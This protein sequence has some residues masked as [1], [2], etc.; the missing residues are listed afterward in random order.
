MV[1]ATIDIIGDPY[2]LD[3]TPAKSNFNDLKVA[4]YRTEKVILF[5]SLGPGEV[6]PDTGFVPEG[7]ARA[8]EFLT[9][10]YRVWKV[11][12]VF[13]NGQ[14]TQKLHVIRDTIT[15]LS[16]LTD[17]VTDKNADN[18]TNVEKPVARP[19]KEKDT[20]Q[21]EAKEET[22]VSKEDVVG[23]KKE[24]GAVNN[25][26]NDKTKEALKKNPNKGKLMIDGKEVSKE[27]YNAHYTQ[28][29]SGQKF[30]GYGSRYSEDKT[31][32]VGGF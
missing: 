20:V 13:D 11:D 21:N 6:D 22:N 5:S 25:Y 1:N 2:W 23:E 10:L 31:R 24:S 14:F 4:N 26:A 18:V 19:V 15:D 9:A 12:H 28:E 27:E 32:V 8:D 29:L 3:Y 16:M 17:T 30:D 7:D